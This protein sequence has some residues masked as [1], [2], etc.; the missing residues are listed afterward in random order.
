MLPYFVSYIS[1]YI[2]IFKKPQVNKA[3]KVEIKRSDNLV[4]DRAMDY[5]LAKVK[6]TRYVKRSKVM[7]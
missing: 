4:M 1:K 6:C 7:H 2:Q 3:M 5:C